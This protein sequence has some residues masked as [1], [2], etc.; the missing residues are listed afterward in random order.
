[1]IEENHLLPF[2][3]NRSVGAAKGRGILVEKE[4]LE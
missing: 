3:L 2:D 4:R 1:M